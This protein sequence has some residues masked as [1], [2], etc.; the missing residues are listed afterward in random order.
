MCCRIAHYHVLNSRF[1]ALRSSLPSMH[2]FISAWL[3]CYISEH[4]ACATQAPTV[5]R[6]VPRLPSRYS[7]GYHGFHRP[8]RPEKSPIGTRQ[9][10]KKKRKPPKR[11][12]KR[13]HSFET[14]VGFP[15]RTP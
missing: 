6:F 10:A 12:P 9:M 15:A 1:T 4:I 2:S 8:L 7:P 5:S 3:S 14:Q 11:S 13:R